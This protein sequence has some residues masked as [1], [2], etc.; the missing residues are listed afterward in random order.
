V[1]Q[2]IIIA[3]PNGAGKTTF[4][5]NYLAGRRAHFAFVNAD[6]IVRDLA[7][8]GQPQQHADIRAARIMLEQIE[9]FVTARADFAF[10]TTLAIRSYAPKIGLWR[11]FGYVASLVYLRL[12]SV[13]VSLERVRRRVEAGGHGIP[14]EIIRRRFGRSAAYFEDP[15]KSLVD[16][17]YIWESSEGDF[18]LAESWHRK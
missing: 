15:Y 3:G 17:W 13:E 18:V 10:E 7:R 4:A 1:P 12:P 5:S 2:V 16:R 14:E 11:R 8:R 9:G 6:E